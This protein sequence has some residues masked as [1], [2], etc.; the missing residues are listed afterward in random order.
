MG[1]PNAVGGAS[2]VERSRKVAPSCTHKTATLE[3]LANWHSKYAQ[4]VSVDR[5]RHAAARHKLANVL[6][7]PRRMRGPSSIWGA[8]AMVVSR[9][10]LLVRIS[11]YPIGSVSVI[12]RAGSLKNL[13]M[14]VKAV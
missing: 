4:F 2:A 14:H 5:N 13:H 9:R 10:P 6:Y 1:W 11:Y 3:A 12:S 8:M 7:E